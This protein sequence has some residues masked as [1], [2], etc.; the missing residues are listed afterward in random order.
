MF[1]PLKVIAIL[2][3]GLMLTFLVFKMIL[4]E[5]KYEDEM[6]AFVAWFLLF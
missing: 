6:F 3:T 1:K 4:F 2:M 5:E